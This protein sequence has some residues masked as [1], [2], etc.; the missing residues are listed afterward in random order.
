MEKKINSSNN[1]FQ[2]I[3]TKRK[4]ML[5]NMNQIQI[6]SHIK[7]SKINNNE[8]YPKRVETNFFSKI[9]NQVNKPKKNVRQNSK[10]IKENNIKKPNKIKEKRKIIIIENSPA[11]KTEIRHDN[12]I[13]K[14]QNRLGI[15]VNKINF[16]KNEFENELNPNCNTTTNTNNTNIN[17]NINYQQI[18]TIYLTK[19]YNATFLNNLT[20]N[21]PNNKIHFYDKNKYNTEANY[22]YNNRTALVK[23]KLT[24]E[25]SKKE[26]KFKDI[27]T[28]IAHIEIFF[29]LYLKKVFNYF[30][31]NMKL[32]EKQKKIKYIYNNDEI[33]ENKFRPIVN[34]NNAHCA[35][36]CS[37]NVNQDK[38]INT[39]LNTQ[40]F[41]SFSKNTYTPLTKKKQSNNENCILKSNDN[42]VFKRNKNIGINPIE[43]NFNTEKF[44]RDNNFNFFNLTKRTLPKNNTDLINEKIYDD[45]NNKTTINNN[46]IKISP[47]KEMNINLGQLNLSK[48]NDID[49]FNLNKTNL[50]K[51]NNKILFNS[52]FKNDL[53]NKM[54]NTNAN[55]YQIN[56]D[57]NKLKKIKSAK[58]DIYIKPKENANK[59]PI[60]EIKIKNKFSP[61]NNISNINIYNSYYK[62]NSNIIMK[63]NNERALNNDQNMIKKIY[64]KRG[65][66]I[67]NNFNCSN[68]PHYSSTFIN[69][70]ADNEKDINDVMLV[71]EIRTLDN[72]LFINVKYLALKKQNNI[73]KIKNIYKSEDGQIVRLYSISIINNEINLNKELYENLKMYNLNNYKDIAD[74]CFFDNDKNKNLKII[75]NLINTIKN[76]ISN[77]ILKR[78]SKK[79][80]KKILLKTLLN[81]NYKRNIK[82]F[83]LK[84]IRN[85]QI[86]T[87]KNI[88]IY[89][90][91]N[92]NDDFNTNNR[93]QTPKNYKRFKRSYNSGLNNLAHDNSLGQNSFRKRIINTHQF[94]DSFSNST[95]KK[96]KKI[97]SNNNQ[98]NRILYKQD[99]VNNYKKE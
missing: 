12:N 51:S 94:T 58:N 36:Y 91:I 67:S 93:L 43:L 83:F 29:S 98:F 18:N 3:K 26:I 84:F 11:N 48:L 49:K 62:M 1:I 61:K 41:S 97:F 23:R 33:K 20:N 24:K 30:I 92:Y 78:L 56:L 10:E 95:F 6:N 44:T 59:Q 47:I 79:Y 42:G 90:K 52:D 57:K 34:V 80:A 96:H 32:Y 28:F 9:N 22:K 25:L 64:I 35:L 85:C 40:N 73:K 53:L 31:E 15:K 81:K 14:L 60:K 19:P 17:T 69:F 16:D 63:K 7:K 5:L 50:H 82:I 72:R 8:I 88:V 68:I 38:L 2:D 89:H 21:S 39:L 37:I 65:S 54:K 87:F 70:K 86:R 74:Y 77:K 99:K 46:N 75:F 66:Q 55:L 27:K 45:D 13:N 4:N 76:I 71:K